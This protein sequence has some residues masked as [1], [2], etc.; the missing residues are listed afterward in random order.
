[1]V[2][3]VC[4]WIPLISGTRGSARWVEREWAGRRGL[5]GQFVYTAELCS[6]RWS[7]NLN[8]LLGPLSR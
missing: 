5:E 8:I 4:P 1:M 7:R 6:R 3:G 2:T